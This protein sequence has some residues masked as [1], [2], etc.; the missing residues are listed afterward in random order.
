[1]QLNKKLAA[2]G[3]LLAIAIP[4]S[5]AEQAQAP[6]FSKDVFPIFQEK[7]NECHRPNTVAP[8]SL[9]SYQTA[10]PWAK[11]IKDRVVSRN[12]PPWQIDRT[13]GIKHFENDPSLTDEQIS[14]IAKWA[15]AGAPE[16]NPKDMP[17]AKTYSDDNDWKASSVMGRPPDMIVKSSPY[18]MN[19]HSQDQWWRPLADIPVTEPTWV[20]AVEI[21]PGTVAGRKITHHALAHLVQA[22]DPDADK[23]SDQIGDGRSP[24]EAGTLME[25]AIGKSYD[26]YADDTGKLLLPGSHVWWDIH[27]HAA[28]ETIRDHVEIGIWFYP[29]DKAPTHR[30]YLTG[31]QS[32]SKVGARLDIPPNSIAMQDGYTVLKAAAKLQNYQPHLHLRGKAMSM[33]AILPDGSTQMLSNVD[34]FDFNWMTNYIYAKDEQ[35][36]LPKGTII[37]I[38]SW[39]DNTAGKKGNPDPN[40]WV[41]WGDRTVDE[42]GHAW[43]NVV[44]IS[45]DEYNTWAAEHKPANNRRVASGNGN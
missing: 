4:M 17:A 44:Y 5:A 18:T 13:V 45:D 35:P 15:D 9:L 7:C 25:W 34:R 16:G 28:G 8:F 1:M 26:V 37:H 40:Q 12:M 21:R 27:Y 29:K 11:A 43:V 33:E 38:T 30:V 39:Y 10:R 42:M 24:N 36:T 3:S 19:A 41:S 23:F 31:F 20:K 22:N 6:T 2:L 14:L 32:T